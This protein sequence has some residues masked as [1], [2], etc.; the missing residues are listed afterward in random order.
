MLLNQISKEL[1]IILYLGRDNMK[2]VLNIILIFFLCVSCE[3]EI[4]NRV[5]LSSKH[6]IWVS[7]KSDYE[8]TIRDENHGDFSSKR[9]IYDRDG[10]S[11]DFL[12][13]IGNAISNLTEKDPIV[14]FDEDIYEMSKE[15]SEN[16]VV[17][18]S[19]EGVYD[20]DLIRVQNVKIDSIGN[21]LVKI[22]S[23]RRG[24]KGLYAIH[25]YC[26]VESKS[27]GCIRMTIRGEDLNKNQEEEL[28][29]LANNIKIGK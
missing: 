6:Q 19:K 1:V 3:N 23:P 7:F 4:D 9:L 11:Y 24:R 15:S 27:L 25:F 14:T 8:Y 20:M 5:E 18:V 13:V 22:L 17:F 26:V 28:L 21:S 10:Q 2:S 12:F 29:R 16:R